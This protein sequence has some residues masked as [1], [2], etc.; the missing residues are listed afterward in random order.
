[1]DKQLQQRVAVI[2]GASSGIGKE[3]AK[4]LVRAGWKV[5]GVGRNQARCDQAAAEILEQ[6]ADSKQMVMIRAD[7]A[8]MADAGRAAAY[9]KQIELAQR[10]VEAAKARH[11]SARGNFADV[12]D[13]QDATNTDFC[14][15][16]LYDPNLV[17]YLELPFYWTGTATDGWGDAPTWRV[18]EASWDALP[19]QGQMRYLMLRGESD[20]YPVDTGEPTETIASA[21]L[22]DDVSLKVYRCFK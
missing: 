22:F 19:H 1:M 13:A 9:E 15:I 20:D 11:P 14:G 17:D 12:I 8:S 3:A 2:T 10:L 16:G 5:L 6:A 7:L 4:V 21:Y 18:F